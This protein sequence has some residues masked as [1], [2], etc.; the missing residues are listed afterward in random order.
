ME[1]I[2]NGTQKKRFVSKIPKALSNKFITLPK[3]QNLK[4][5]SVTRRKG[6]IGRRRKVGLGRERKAFL[7]KLGI[8]TRKVGVGFVLAGR[9]GVGVSQVRNGGIDGRKVCLRGRRKALKRRRPFLRRRKASI[10]TRKVGV[11]I[12]LMGVEVDQVRK[13][14]R[15]KRR[16]RRRRT[17]IERTKL[18]LGSRRALERR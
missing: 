18:C 11:V 1:S 4:S 13:G 8:A 17:E 6:D 3:I 7:R 12:A 14:R 16:R 2:K 10:G 5:L 15:G 9:A